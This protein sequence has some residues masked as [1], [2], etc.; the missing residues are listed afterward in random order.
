MATYRNKALVQLMR[1]PRTYVWVRRTN[2]LLRFVFFSRLRR[3][4]LPSLNT[5]QVAIPALPME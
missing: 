2:I 1:W 4:C 3:M 5:W